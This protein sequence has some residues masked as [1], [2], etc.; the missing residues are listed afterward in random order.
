MA[1]HC[2]NCPNDVIV[3]YFK[4]KYIN[5]CLW[6]LMQTLKKIWFFGHP[7]QIF[8]NEMDKTIIAFTEC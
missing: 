2:L 6:H 1:L 4:T 5:M 3:S 7:F 8:F